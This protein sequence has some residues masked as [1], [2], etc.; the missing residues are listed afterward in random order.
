MTLDDIPHRSRRRRRSSKKSRS[1]KKR[2]TVRI[3]AWSLLG[4]FTLAIFVTGAIYLVLSMRGEGT[5]MPA[6]APVRPG[7]PP[8]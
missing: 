7:L 8:G 3:V 2:R 1:R 4:L 5:D 6:A